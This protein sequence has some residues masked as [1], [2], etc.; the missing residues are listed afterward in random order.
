VRQFVKLAL[1]MGGIHPQVYGQ[2]VMGLFNVVLVTVMLWFY[3][4]YWQ[5]RTPM[6]YPLG[7][8]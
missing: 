3:R 8:R 1:L 2:T 4:A 5:D 7:G 6:L